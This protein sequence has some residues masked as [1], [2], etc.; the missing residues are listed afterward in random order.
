MSHLR[1]VT[2]EDAAKIIQPTDTAEIQAVPYTTL[3]GWG[4][5]VFHGRTPMRTVWDR[6]WS[7]EDA[8]RE[9]AKAVL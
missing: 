8:R 9:A 4:Y 2:A 1:S 7:A 3:G 5:I 6:T